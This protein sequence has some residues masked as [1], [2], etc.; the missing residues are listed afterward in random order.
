V[1]AA[2]LVGDAEVNEGA[3]GVLAFFGQVH[4]AETAGA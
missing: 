3:E 4:G 1:G 2:D